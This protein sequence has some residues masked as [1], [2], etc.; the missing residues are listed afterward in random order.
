MIAHTFLGVTFSLPLMAAG[1]GIVLLY[2]LLRS[3]GKGAEWMGPAALALG[4]GLA[5]ASLVFP[6]LGA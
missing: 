6:D 4:I 1:V 5:G 3:M 2:A